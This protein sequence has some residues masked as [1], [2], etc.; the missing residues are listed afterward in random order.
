MLSSAELR[1]QMYTGGAGG[2]GGRLCGGV[3]HQRPHFLHQ[4]Q[5]HP[6]A[7][8]GDANGQLQRVRS[9]MRLFYSEVTL[10]GAE[11]PHSPSQDQSICWPDMLNYSQKHELYL[12]LRLNRFCKYVLKFTGDL[13]AIW[14]LSH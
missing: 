2:L 3:Q 4:R 7:D 11:P 1:G 10:T 12:I 9:T 6:A 8:S 5:E 14:G 13:G